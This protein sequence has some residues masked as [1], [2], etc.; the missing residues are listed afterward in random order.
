MYVHKSECT[1]I[2]QYTKL[3]LRSTL[4]KFDKVR[5]DTAAIFPHA[6]L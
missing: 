3:Y 6:R 1:Y 5:S 2:S 4:G